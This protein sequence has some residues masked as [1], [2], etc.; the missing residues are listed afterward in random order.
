M[1]VDISFTKTPVRSCLLYYQT[2]CVV[3]S[4]FLKG[5]CAI[6]A[7]G[8]QARENKMNTNPDPHNLIQRFVEI[9]SRC[10]LPQQ[11]SYLSTDFSH[12][13]YV[14]YVQASLKTGSTSINLKTAKTGFLPIFDRFFVFWSKKYLLICQID[15]IKTIFIKICNN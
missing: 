9:Y 15:I 13:W 3:I 14:S 2:C 6:A 12:I 4:E 10:R 1:D 7:R 11:R 8:S 5:K